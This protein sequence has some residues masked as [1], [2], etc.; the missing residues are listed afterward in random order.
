M[1]TIT[2][3]LCAL[4]TVGCLTVN[5]A[6]EKRPVPKEYEGIAESTPPKKINWEKR[7]EFGSKGNVTVYV[8]KNGIPTE[9]Y[10]VGVAPVS[11]TLIAVEAEE[12]AR[13][14]A[15]F[16][17]KAAFAL[18]MSERFAVKNERDKK[19]LI[20]RKN[21]KESSESVTISKRHAEQMASAAWRGMS[22]FWHKRSN[23]RY[24]V[25]WRWSVTEQRL[26]K[27][28]EMLTRDGDPASLKRKADM[29]VKDI[30]GTFR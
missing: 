25:V 19:I 27:M 2:G 11:T 15:E 5:A 3:F 30:E 17:A 22:V 12:D 6:D 9:V 10:V 16:S 14:E 23:G 26:A 21:G 1:K 18:W 8:D 29:E 20:V 28:V 4:L 7:T 13:E 24:I